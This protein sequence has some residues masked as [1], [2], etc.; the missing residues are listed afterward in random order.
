MP[1]GKNAKP[2]MQASSTVCADQQSMPA[3]LLTVLD[4]CSEVRLCTAQHVQ[5]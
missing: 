3:L 5:V 1:E 4:A 2:A